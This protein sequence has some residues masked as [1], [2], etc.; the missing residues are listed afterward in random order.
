MNEIIMMSSCRGL[1]RCGVLDVDPTRVEMGWIID[2]CA[3]S[4]RNI[5][6]GIG[7]RQDGFMMQSKVWYCRQFRMYGYSFHCKGSWPT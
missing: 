1:P 4:L 7:G 2:F 5:I 3:Q 6:I